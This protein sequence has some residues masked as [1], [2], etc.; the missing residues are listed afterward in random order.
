MREIRSWMCRIRPEN[1]QRDN[2]CVTANHLINTKAL[3]GKYVIRDFCS[4][5]DQILS[6]G[7]VHPLRSNEEI[8]PGISRLR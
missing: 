4:R 3:W 2:F 5:K 7:E 8:V 6:R 1:I